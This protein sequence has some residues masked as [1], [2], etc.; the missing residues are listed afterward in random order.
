MTNFTAFEILL[1]DQLMEVKGG[2]GGKVGSFDL[3]GM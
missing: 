3:D 2:S 1:D